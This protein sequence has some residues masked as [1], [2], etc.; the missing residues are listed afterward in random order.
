MRGLVLEGGAMLGLFTCGVIDFLME[1]D[2][3]F[4]GLIGVSAG[5]AFG[6]NYKS[7]QIGRGLR[8]NKA[9]CRDPRYC[10][11]RSFL[12]TGDM[13]NAKFCYHVLPVEL[14]PFD[15]ETFIRDPMDFYLVATDVRT[16][17][18]VYKKLKTVDYT[19]FEWFRAS[20]SMPLVSNMVIL[21]GMRLLDGGIADSI[22]LK[23]F[24]KQGYDRTV[25][26][27]TK[28]R[29]YVKSAYPAMSLAKWKYKDYPKFV[30]AL[31]NRHIMYNNQMRYVLDRERQGKTFVIAP[32]Q[33]L[34]IGHITHDPDKLQEV[35]DIGR[36]EAKRVFPALKSYLG[37]G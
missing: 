35:Y 12:K 34:P 19:G 37:L 5:A 23:F 10:S 24:E 36:A 18:P 11:I 27:L 7:H 22:P 25:T 9:Y 13:Y 14:D 2:V 6:C 21:D 33:T 8:Y 30:E 15:E 1:E 4:D 32:P 29:D 17:R 31:G 20:G 26:V 3:K 28:P 16:G